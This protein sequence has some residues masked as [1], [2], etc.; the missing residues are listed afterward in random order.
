MQFLQQCLFAK[1]QYH[2]HLSPVI[3][4]LSFFML[5][6][7]MLGSGKQFVLRVSCSAHKSKNK[8]THYWRRH[9]EQFTL[10]NGYFYSWVLRGRNAGI[11]HNA[12]YHPTPFPQKM[13]TC[14]GSSLN[15]H[16]L[17]SNICLWNR[18][19]KC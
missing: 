5:H 3:F 13:K 7:E 1:A 9:G 14:G 10:T 2:L 19:V 11:G 12:V 16:G 17:T 6:G 4:L 8:N 15:A 18:P